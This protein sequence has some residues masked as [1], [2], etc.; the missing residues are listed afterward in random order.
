M[1]A[2]AKS[3][4]GFVGAGRMGAPMVERLVKAG[5]DVRVLGRS[6]EKCVAISELG[7]TAV[8]GLDEVA[9]DAAVV[10]ICV[11]TDAQVREICLD[12]G[13][14]AAMPTG[15]VLV[16]HTT[17]SPRTAEL[18][19]AAAPGIAVLDA[20]VS[21]GPH[22]IAAGNITLFVGG[23]VT[24]LE[25]ARPVL[26]AYADPILHVGGLGTGQWVKLL[27]NAMFAAQLGMLREAASFAAHVGVRE[28]GLLEAVGHGSGASRAAE[29]A[30]ARGSV[31]SFIE[32]VGEFLG[33]D[34]AVVREVAAEAGGDLGLLEGLLDLVVG[35]PTDGTPR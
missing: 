11:F 32:S 24:A 18:L 31:Q 16:V 4:V 3:A 22:D 19:A 1:S 9:V 15:S 6:A 25:A 21:G 17:G 23:D 28:A 33:K 35:A 27:N 10:V 14:L 8:T 20:P 13:L 2:C 5:H 12:G 29:I 30:G 7:A 26:A 34:V